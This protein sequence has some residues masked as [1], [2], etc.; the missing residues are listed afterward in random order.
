MADS[1]AELQ[2][3]Q[4]LLEGEQKLRTAAEMAKMGIVYQVKQGIAKIR[5]VGNVDSL[6]EKDVGGIIRY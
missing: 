6:E 1:E 3:T 5:L 4:K 2:K